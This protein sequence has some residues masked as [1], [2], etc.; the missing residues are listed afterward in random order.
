LVHNLKERVTAELNVKFGWHLDSDTIRQAVNEA[1]ALAASTPF[2]T[3]FL[4]DLAE[5]KA[6]AA[7]QWRVRQSAIRRRSLA[8]AA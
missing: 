7:A 4:P 6:R 1:D 5:E 2:P 3:L 8:F